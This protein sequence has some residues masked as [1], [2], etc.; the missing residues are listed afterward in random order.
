MEAVGDKKKAD[1]FDKFMKSV[2]VCG[3]IIGLILIALGIYLLVT[4]ANNLNPRNTVNN[5]FQIIFGIFII[6]AELRITSALKYFYFMQH[7][8]GLGMFYIF[9]GGLALGGAWYQIAV[10]AVC[11]GLGLIYFVLGLGCRRMGRENFKRSGVEIDPV[12]AQGAVPAAAHS[13]GSAEASANP[14][15]NY[16]AYGVAYGNGGPAAAYEEPAAI[17]AARQNASAYTNDEPA[18]YE[19]SPK[20]SAY[21]G[22]AQSA[23]SNDAEIV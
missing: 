10:A 2:R 12:L 7:F 9:L 5:V 4:I 19:S 22:A 3:I 18:A 15:G 17:K 1:R 6:V 11:L 14:K 13:G 23:Y 16:G 8:L 21:D 20:A